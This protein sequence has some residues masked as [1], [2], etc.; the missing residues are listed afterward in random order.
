MTASPDLA[1]SVSCQLRSAI[2]GRSSR[3]KREDGYSDLQG[4][5]LHAVCVY[6]QPC[7][8]VCVYRCRLSC[9]DHHGTC[10]LPVGPRRGDGH[11]VEPSS[12]WQL[13]GTESMRRLQPV[14]CSHFFIQCPG[15][16]NEPAS[17]SQAVVGVGVGGRAVQCPGTLQ[18]SGWCWLRKYCVQAGLVRRGLKCL[19]HLG[20]PLEEGLRVLILHRPRPLHVAQ[21]RLRCQCRPSPTRA[22]RFLWRSGA[23]GPFPDRRSLRDRQNIKAVSAAR[24]RT[25][26]VY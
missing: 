12:E 6:T 9:T 4:Q 11:P 23:G 24:T 7:W 21:D 25:R 26:M 14:E 22:I 17:P 1:R 8:L 3:Q 5:V 18:L 2:R 13:S 16:N 15:L 10:V 20:T 19:G